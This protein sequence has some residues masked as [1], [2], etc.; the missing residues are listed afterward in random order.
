M[1]ARLAAVCSCWFVWFA[2][3]PFLSRI[4]EI[5][6]QARNDMR[7]NVRAFRGLSILRQASPAASSHH[8]T[9]FANWV[10]TLAKG[11][12]S[13]VRVYSKKSFNLLLRDGCLNLRNA[14]ASIWRMRSRVT[15]NSRPTSSKVRALPSSKP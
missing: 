9:Q 7:K 8:P 10:G 13:R 2:V 11:G 12:L 6:G 1:F 4:T 14:L 3:N 15:L 5:A